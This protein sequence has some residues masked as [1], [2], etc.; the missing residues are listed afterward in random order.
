MV[1]L[2]GHRQGIESLHQHGDVAVVEELGCLMGHVQN[3]PDF[4]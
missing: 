2:H 3:R 1:S 4:I